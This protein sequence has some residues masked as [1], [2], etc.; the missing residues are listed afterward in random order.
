MSEDLPVESSN[1]QSPR[2]EST[3]D[4]NII[5]GDENLNIE[6]DEYIEEEY[7][8]VEEYIE[9]EVV[10]EEAFPTEYEYVYEETT[11]TTTK[12]TVD[13]KI[14]ESKTTNDETKSNEEDRT[15]QTQGDGDVL[16]N[17]EAT[18]VETPS[19]PTPNVPQSPTKPVHR[20]KN[21][22][23]NFPPPTPEFKE[24]KTS[25]PFP[26]QT[27]NSG[28]ESL[29]QNQNRS[30]KPIPP[31]KPARPP[32]KFPFIPPTELQPQQASPPNSRPST[33]RKYP[34]QAPPTPPTSS[35]SGSRTE[36]TKRLTI[37][38]RPKSVY[39]IQLSRQ[40]YIPTKPL[41]TYDLQKV[42]KVQAIIRGF[43]AR[44]KLK[45]LRKFKFNTVLYLLFNLF[46]NIN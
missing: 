10:V 43:I 40:P 33:E 41:E 3:S 15:T 23:P 44:R 25:P 21:I 28:P 16:A 13:N 46:F 24:E 18:K 29:E 17:K 8:Y 12:E 31:P 9:E 11:T 34:T 7:E 20:T 27:T 6:H 42:I 30:D 32:R 19:E 1:T 36:K 39:A 5:Y 38:M 2:G 4:Y 37:T 22:L 26:P 14:D 35:P 45:N